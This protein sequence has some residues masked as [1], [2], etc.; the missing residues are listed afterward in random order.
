[1]SGLKTS[2][3]ILSHIH[4][5]QGGPWRFGDQPD[6]REEHANLMNIVP[7]KAWCAAGNRLTE[8]MVKLDVRGWSSDDRYVLSWTAA[9][10]ACGCIA[11]GE[12]QECLR[13]I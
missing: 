2:K 10:N 9:Q 12:A 6:A 8:E 3:D 11:R 1:M 13:I 7:W 4:R 5:W